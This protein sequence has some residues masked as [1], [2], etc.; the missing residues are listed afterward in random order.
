[1]SYAGAVKGLTSPGPAAAGGKSSGAD[2]ARSALLAVAPA[3]GSVPACPPITG[4]T[5]RGSQANMLELLVPGMRPF[6]EAYARAH[7]QQRQIAAEVLGSAPGIIAAKY[8]AGAAPQ[9]PPPAKGAAA[10]PVV[11]AGPP[12]A[13]L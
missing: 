3:P 9:P 11:G 6:L 10:A 13:S 5:F 2:L 8:G 12:K 1:M 4:E 7:P